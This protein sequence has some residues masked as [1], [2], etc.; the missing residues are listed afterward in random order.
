MGVPPSRWESGVSSPRS[1]RPRS[2]DLQLKSPLKKT[3]K[4]RKTPARG[5]GDFVLRG[6]PRGD[7]SCFSESDLAEARWERKNSFVEKIGETEGGTWFPL[8]VLPT[9][10]TFDHQVWRKVFHHDDEPAD[11]SS[12]WRS[13]K[14][15]RAACRRPSSTDGPHSSSWSPRSGSSSPRLKP[16]RRKKDGLKDGPLPPNLQLDGAIQTL[17]ELHH[18]AAGC[19]ND[20][21]EVKHEVPWR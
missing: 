4:N 7:T 11:L 12:D 6:K 21:L 20:L 19:P 18:A 3:K 1:A 5:F 16:L 8:L 13:P 17:S 2:N 10:K 15:W 9:I 14:N